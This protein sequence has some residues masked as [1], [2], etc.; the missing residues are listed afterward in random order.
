M[1]A[2][3]GE[4]HVVALGTQRLPI[5]LHRSDRKTLGIAVHP[6]TSIVVTAPFKA[7]LAAI[8]HIMAKRGGW[9]L[10]AVRDFER[11]LPHTPAAPLCFRRDALLSRT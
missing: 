8:E 1:T 2:A 5:L 10:R 11:F 7:D 4:R 9:I 3:E 6:D